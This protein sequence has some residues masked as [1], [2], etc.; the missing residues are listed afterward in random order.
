KH[1]I[2]TFFDKLYFGDTYPNCK[3]NIDFFMRILEEFRLSPEQAIIVGDSLENDLLPCQN[4][5]IKTLRY[6]GEKSFKEI[7]TKLME[8]KNGS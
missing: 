7:H 8:V 2:I 4:L 6:D 1:K 5:G 3:P